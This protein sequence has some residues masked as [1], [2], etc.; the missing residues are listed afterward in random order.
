MPIAS[1]A[2]GWGPTQVS[3]IAAIEQRPRAALG[4]FLAIHAVLWTVLPTLVYPNLPLD[5]IEAL[6]YGREWQLGYDK[7]PPL[8]WW[9]VEIVYRTI[10][11]DIGYYLLA[12]IAVV[13]AFIAIYL[14]SRPLVGDLRALIAILII[15]GLHFFNFTAEKF[16]HDVIQLPFWA[17][18]A[19]TFHRVLRGGG[20][21]YWLLFGLAV[22]V[23]LWAKYFF[24]VLVAPLA[25]FMV[26]DREARAHLPTPGP[27]LAVAVALI[28]T[29]PHLVWLVAHNFLP[30]V[31]A[32]ARAATSRGLIDH[33]LHP[34]TFAG[35]QLFFLLPVLVIA[36]P[37]C[38]RER[39]PVAAAAD[40]Y[41]RRIVT[42]LA[43]GPAAALLALLALS[44]RGAIAMWGYPLW[45]CLG[46]WIVMTVEPALD[47]LQ[48]TR[49][50][51]IWAFVTA[52][53]GI[54]F[55]AN[56]VF[57]PSI[58]GRYR[59]VLY[60]GQTL[61]TEISQRFRAATGQPLRY[62]IGRTWDG[63]NIAHYSSDR[64]RV[65]IDGNPARSPWIDLSDLRRHGAVVLWTSADPRP[66]GIPTEFSFAT[67]AAVMQPPFTL[68]F[69]RGPHV[70]RVTWAVLYPSP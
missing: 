46:L 51:A 12:Q 52:A 25:L 43:F 61:A 1:A 7:L 34:L 58:D 6:T 13:S 8:P 30:F 17:L 69:H 22:G 9:L 39:A 4:W 18:A 68:P 15:D 26:F 21:R 31:Y 56:Y 59:A 27:Y 70:L 10:G 32:E 23:S 37:L 66:N 29:A 36:A 57:L 49:I 3:L 35:G 50:V 54:A 45:L 28:V 40:A 47:R 42:L 64:P 33:V 44:G 60:P 55:V 48:L 63:G 5:L 16:N 24:V 19:L 67:K 53:F 62:V 65:L 38:S 2:W 20:M 11:H 41:D 14:L